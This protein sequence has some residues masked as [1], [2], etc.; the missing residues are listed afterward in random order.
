VNLK[1]NSADAAISLG[2]ACLA[3]D[4]KDGMNT[5]GVITN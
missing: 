1:C 5:N 2:S 4:L 3:L